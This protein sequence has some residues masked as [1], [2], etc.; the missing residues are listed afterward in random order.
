MVLVGSSAGAPIAGQICVCHRACWLML[1]LMM[2]MMMTVTDLR[3]PSILLVDVVVDD[4]GDR[5]ASPSSPS[6]PSSP[7]ASSRLLFT[8]AANS[9]K[10]T[11]APGLRCS[12]YRGGSVAGSAVEEFD[13]IKGYVGIGYVFG[14]LASLLFSSHYGR[15]RP[16]LRDPGPRNPRHDGIAPQAC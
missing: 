14:C 11:P 13:F 10:R 15:S 7:A 6:F 3:M 12:S 2:M 4:D 16:Q 9:I 8:A 1:L 5:L